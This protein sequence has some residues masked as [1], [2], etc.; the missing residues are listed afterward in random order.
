MKIEGINCGS[1]RGMERKRKKRCT[2]DKKDDKK[3]EKKQYKRRLLP[4]ASRLDD[5][6]R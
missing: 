6:W 3:W 2:E 1:R 4:D 5:V